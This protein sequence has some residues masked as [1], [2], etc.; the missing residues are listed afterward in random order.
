[1]FR[2][3]SRIDLSL[4]PRFIAAFCSDADRL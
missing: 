2:T 4:T 1:M 3:A